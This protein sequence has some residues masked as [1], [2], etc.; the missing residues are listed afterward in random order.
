MRR[1]EKH[2]VC[3]A[4]GLQTYSSHKA[5]P[6]VHTKPSNPGDDRMHG[7]RVVLKKGWRSMFLQSGKSHLFVG[8]MK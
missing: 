1:E 3:T 5:L 2:L 6:I 7:D 8:R 4:A